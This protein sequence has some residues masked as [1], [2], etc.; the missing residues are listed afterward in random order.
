MVDA[1]NLER[2]FYLVVQLLELNQPTV[3]VLNMMDVVGRHKLRID[4]AAL[5]RALGAPVVPATARR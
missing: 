3:V 2:N 4:V 1:A 5:S